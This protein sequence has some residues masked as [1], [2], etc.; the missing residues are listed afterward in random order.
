MST[1]H[2]RTTNMAKTLAD[3]LEV[4]GSTIKLKEDAYGQTL[5][6]EITI[7]TAKAVH[8]HDR[9][10]A[11]G[12]ALAVGEKAVEILNKD[13]TLSHVTASTNIGFS[14]V[15]TVVKRESTVNIPPKKEGDPV[16]KKTI[17]GKV[18][19]SQTTKSGAEMKRV[20]QHVSELAVAAFG[21]SKK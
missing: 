8:Q 21:G 7:E 5:P 6:G 3:H 17:I 16:G 15:D 14:T 20:K 9:D 1:I 13:K 2:E 10:Y 12:F 11:H 18:E 4:E 19:V